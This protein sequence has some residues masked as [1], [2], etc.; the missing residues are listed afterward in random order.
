MGLLAFAFLAPCAVRAQQIT[1]T[2]V[3]FKDTDSTGAA[4]AHA[5][6]ITGVR[7][8][9]GATKT[10]ERGHLRAELTSARILARQ[11]LCEWILRKAG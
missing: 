11:K 2:A 4:I 10:D 9:M 8:G 7:S 6:V 1:T 5:Q 3:T